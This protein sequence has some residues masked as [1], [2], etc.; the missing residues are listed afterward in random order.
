MYHE[1]RRKRLGPGRSDLRRHN[2]RLSVSGRV[3]GERAVGS[4]DLHCS[5][6]G[7]GWSE[8]AGEVTLPPDTAHVGVQ[9]MLNGT[10]EAWLDDVSAEFT[11]SE[12]PTP[13]KTTTAT[14]PVK[15]KDSSEPAESYFPDHPDAWRQNAASQTARSMQGNIP[16][17]FFGDSLTQNWCGQAGWTER[18][19]KLGAVNYGVGGDGTPQ[20]LWRIR[21]GL[22]D[23]IQ[24]KAIVL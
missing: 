8:V 5:M 3:R 13:P 12:I 23:G 1:P 9:L 20:V 24:P 22:L 7:M 16:T 11:T 18:Y 15:A 17:V 19:A 2:Q 14:T 21:E 10:G 6:T 4:A